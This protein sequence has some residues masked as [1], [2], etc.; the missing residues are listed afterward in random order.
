M[1]EMT[2]WIQECDRPASNPV[3]VQPQI[4]TGET[5]ISIEVGSTELPDENGLRCGGAPVASS[6]RA[7]LENHQRDSA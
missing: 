6:L 3:T 2:I 4:D 5:R 7:L 1:K